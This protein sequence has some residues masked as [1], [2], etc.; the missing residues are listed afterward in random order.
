[1]K[2]NVERS[3]FAVVL[4]LGL[5][6][7]LLAGLAGNRSDLFAS[8]Q[9]A[10]AANPTTGVSDK[11]AALVERDADADQTNAA[12][13]SRARVFVVPAESEWLAAL[14]APVAA[15][16][17]KKRETPLLLV[18]PSAESPAW[19]AAS[20]WRDAM[21]ITE[22][23]ATDESHGRVAVS[24][25][26]VHA[27]VALALKY[28]GKAERV[29]IAD[30]RNPSDQIYAAALAA[31]LREPLLLFDTA[32]Q[33][34][35]LDVVAELEAKRA[36]VVGQSHNDFGEPVNVDLGVPTERLD[37][38]SYHK[39]MT[40]LLGRTRVKTMVLARVP[41]SYDGIGATA[42]LAPYVSLVRRAPVL[43]TP[44]DQGE[45]AEQLVRYHIHANRLR[46]RS[47]LILADYYSIAGRTITIPNA[48]ADDVDNYTLTVD[49]C[50]VPTEGYAGSLA[51]GRIPFASPADAALM[52]ARG[53]AHRQVIDET[54][55]SAVVIA[56]PKSSHG[57]LPLCETV[58]RATVRELKNRS[59]NV[60]EFYD[61]HSNAEPVVE[62]VERAQLVL[63]EGHSS[64][65]YLF[66]PTYD[67]DN[68]D[69]TFET[70]TFVETIEERP[71]IR[72]GAG[73]YLDGASVYP[74]T[75][76]VDANRARGPP[77]V[78]PGAS[79]VV[80]LLMLLEEKRTR[81]RGPRSEPT[82]KNTTEDAEPEDA[83][84]PAD[85]APASDD[86]GFDSDDPEFADQYGP[87]PGATIKQLNGR[88]I[89]ILQSCYSLNDQALTRV[90]DLGGVALV[91]SATKIHSASG[92]TFMKAMLDG[93]IYR[94]D[95]V[96]EAL[97]D[98]RN[99]FLCLQDLKN[100]RGHTQQ[101]KSYRVALSFTL[102]G[103]PEVRVFPNK[104]APPHRE[105]VKAEWSGPARITLTMP[106]KRL[107][108]VKAERYVMKH[109]PGS[110][111]A[112]VVKRKG[113][114]DE[115]P[116][117]LLPFHFA[118]LE[119]PAG[120]DID[121][122]SR[123]VRDGDKTV[124]AVFRTDEQRRYLYVLYFPFNEKPEARYDLVFKP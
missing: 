8:R 114:G 19:D 36:I 118:R 56:N 90:H 109:F 82:D 117:H 27:A 16:V 5:S 15:K 67:F 29:V 64:D 93:V 55:S 41:N 63:Y 45:H 74:S 17:V 124:R 48:P 76:D 85:D 40:K 44:T 32:R 111:A 79:T 42:W 66:V 92:S 26:P 72:D 23:T 9:Q 59:V 68:P 58:S 80:E 1:M 46:P 89:V 110:Q 34:L 73:G 47:L 57:R 119:M 70:D 28:W 33:R 107:P 116:R 14:V 83:N 94:G 62:A 3:E 13:E 81:D 35:C 71:M 10:I 88:P 115:A 50:A 100:Q 113:E 4:A 18:R 99:Y 7:L 77:L 61:V 37:G 53:V 12:T 102:W 75:E 49:P 95:T 39:R 30:A 98:A 87:P 2:T 121:R 122:Y 51:V 21:P 69:Q 38:A 78:E 65:Q 101:A 105:T 52:F 96:G 106:E 97:R 43:L 54:K 123:L 31:R 25:D 24:A 112:G 108:T 60:A 91:G 6:V 104:L 20:L 22:F 103:D 84:E 86:N 11:Q 120:F